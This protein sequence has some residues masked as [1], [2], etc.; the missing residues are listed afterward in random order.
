MPTA[1][2]EAEPSD[3]PSRSAAARGFR[4]WVLAGLAVLVVAGG[5]LGTRRFAARADAQLRDRLLAQATELAHTLDPELVKSLSFSPADESRPEF[6]RLRA[7]MAAAAAAL[8]VRAV[9][10]LALRDGRIV[11]GPEN[12]ASAAP[13]ATRPGTVH[14]RPAPEARAVFESGRPVVFGPQTD[15]SGTFIAA[16]APVLDPRTGK[17]LLVVGTKLETGS[18]RAAVTRARWVPLL[19]TLVLLLTLAA[20]AVALEWRWRQPAAA[21]DRLRHVETVLCAVFGLVLTAAG[22]WL[23]HAEAAFLAQHPLWGGC[24]TGLAGLL[25]TALLASV[26]SLLGHRR[27]ELEQQVAA[28]TAALEVARAETQEMLVATEQSH[29]TLRNMVEV[30]QAAEAALLESQAVLQTAMDCS[31]AGIAIADAPSGKLRYVN[32]AGQRIRGAAVTESLNDVDLTNYAARWQLFDL[33]GTALATEEMP[34][35]WA[36]LNGEPCS[37]EFIIRRSPTDERIVWG[38]GA[39]VLDPEGKTLAAILV[40]LDI[41]DR[42]RTAAALV[43]SE[44]QYRLLFENLTA[45]FAL[46][47]MLYDDAGRPTDYR[48]LAAN[49][50]FERL[51]GLTVAAILGRTAREVMP[52][53]KPSGLELYAKVVQTGAPA[54]YENHSAEAHK[55]F[56]T[57]VFRPAPNHFAVV[58]TDI[59]A[60]RLAEA[61]IR[62]LNASLEQRVAERTAQL[63]AANKELEAFSYSVSHDLRA[64][65]RA[66]AGYAGMLSEDHAVSLDAEGNRMLAVVSAEAQRMGV[67]IDDLLA[68]SRLG[69]QPVQRSTVDQEALAK[70]VFA[71]LAAREPERRLH[72]SVLPMPPVPGDPAL[73]RQVWVNLLGNA[74]KYTRHTAEARIEVG[75]LTTGAQ[76]AYYVKDNGVGFDM[77]YAGKL[78][79]VFQRLHREAEFEG[80]GVGL[81]LVQ[82]IIHRH[83]GRIWAEA[84]PGEGAT[85]FFTIASGT[86]PT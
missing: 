29:R 7:Q 24:L 33:D 43:E 40:F 8:D 30:Q 57:W 17:V 73:L 25:L 46:H 53:G 32:R 55:D 5:F 71:E 56:D 21:Q 70:A 9:Y 67:L 20:G 50:A 82:R 13:L 19:L 61:E 59:T 16:L 60:R 75:S 69:R 3:P 37:R 47:E 79:G 77:R 15:E 72:F 34:L 58:F 12:L 28:R 27:A 65:L 10:S 83:G 31:Q 48:F 74:I 22:G 63:E 35:A 18:W 62:Q 66:I 39:P 64:P 45:G 42:K 14:Q 78:F 2:A 4:P 38:N 1:T 6:Q 54:A 26:V 85:F 52:G 44:R 81:A 80:T 68:F 23:V 11:F 86:I 76:V 41:T 49:P 36:I 51:T 84:R